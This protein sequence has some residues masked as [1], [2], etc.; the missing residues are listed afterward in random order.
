MDIKK[1]PDI[2]YY[3]RHRASAQ[4]MLSR[5]STAPLAA[6]TP[7]FGGAGSALIDSFGG[8]SHS[9]FGDMSSDDMSEHLRHL[10]YLHCHADN[11]CYKIRRVVDVP[12][13]ARSPATGVLETVSIRTRVEIRIFTTP[14]L[15]GAKIR[16][17]I[18][19]EFMQGMVTGRSDEDALFKVRLSTGELG[20]EAKSCTLFFRSV[21]EY[22]RHFRAKCGPFAAPRRNGGP[23]SIADVADSIR[24]N[25]R[26]RLSRETAVQTAQLCTVVH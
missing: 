13:L 7:L 19:G 4:S 9:E 12:K 15:S 10:L 3:R 25:C 1:L 14:E 24:Q 20:A 6:P 17:A 23:R 11:G 26:E 5:A 21:E 18:T 2:R 22:E 8:Y 16:D